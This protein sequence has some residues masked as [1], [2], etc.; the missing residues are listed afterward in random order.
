MKPHYSVALLIETSSTYGRQI[1]RGIQ[2]FIHS[3]NSQEW[4]AVVEERDVNAGAPGWIRNWS[5]DGIISRQTSEKFHQAILNRDISFVELTDRHE[6]RRVTSVCSDDVGIGRLAAEHLRDR[7][8]SNFAFCGFRGEAWSNRRHV[9]FQSYLQSIT[10]ASL[11]S[12]QSVWYA[13][14]LK[15][16]VAWE[17]KLTRWLQ[18]LPKPIGVMAC[19][20]VAGKQIIDCCHRASISVPESVA[21]IGVDNDD[22]LCNFCHTPLSSVIPNAEG[23]GFRSA[24]LLSEML[25]GQKSR[26]AVQEVIVPPLGVFA[27]QSSDIVAV[28]DDDLAATLRF[29]RN[30]ACTGISVADVV[31][32]SR[33]SRSSIER[34]MR[35]FIG[36][37]PQQEIRRVR[38]RQACEL[39]VAT[40]L[41]VEVIALQCGYE[42]PEYLHVVFKR[43][44]KMTPS[45]YRH[46][47]ENR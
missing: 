30:H 22:L 4:T 42:H 26:N 16:R 14:D 27:R 9:G 13:H 38:L 15:R 33:M 39:L 20:D 28:N 37:T 32:Q 34:K 11:H 21:V 45:E 41:S 40:D 3:D 1:L 19:N 7:G 47:A 31:A 23:V 25:Q 35:D 43:E 29:I 46:A 5:G 24:K 12:F 8:L 6:S 17:A 2:R 10:N 44:M 18:G 36:R